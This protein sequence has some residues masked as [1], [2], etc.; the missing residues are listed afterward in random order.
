MEKVDA[1]QRHEKLPVG[2]ECVDSLMNGGLESGVITEFYGEGGSGKSNMSML[3]ALSAI[4]NGKSAVFLDTEGFSS[5]RFLQVCGGSSE[6]AENLMLYRISSL[7]DQE[8]S[9]MRV[10]KMLEKS[11]KIGI[12]IVDSFTEYF[13][14]EKTSDAQSRSAGF[15][16]QLGLLSSIALKGNIPVLITNQIYQDVESRSLNP[17]GGFIVD[18]SMKAIYE[19]EKLPD[20]K[21]RISVSKHRSIP[22]GKYAD[23]K[24]MDYGISCEA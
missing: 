2:V 1:A 20:G 13:R 23:F 22:D 17:F 8:L 7:D 6:P 3:F 11:G 14:L 16:K 4:R 24:I 19:L 18:H 9:I 5:D 12:V 15:Q 10:G 21:R